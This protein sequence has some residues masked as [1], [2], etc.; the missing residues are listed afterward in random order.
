MSDTISVP[1]FRANSIVP[2]SLNLSNINGLYSIYEYLTTTLGK[3][4]AI[5]LK[6][7]F[8]TRQPLTSL[9]MSVLSIS[10]ILHIIHEAGNKE[11]LVEMHPVSAKSIVNNLA[12]Q[13]VSDNPTQ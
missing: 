12:T 11:G 4:G 13:P 7:K 2:I 10:T 8:E 6:A 9:E 5:T 1:H 3:G